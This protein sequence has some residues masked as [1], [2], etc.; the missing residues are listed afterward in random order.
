MSLQSP[1]KISGLVLVAPLTL[2][3]Q[4]MTVQQYLQQKE[5]TDNADEAKAFLQH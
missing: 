1:E 4:P 3:P 5:W 2:T